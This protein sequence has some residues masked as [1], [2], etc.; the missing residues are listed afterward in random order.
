MV[1][2]YY[3]QGSERVGPVGIETL[4]EL[5]HQGVLNLESYIWKK[6]FQNW[7]RLKDVSELDF[8][9]PATASE[10]T[11]VIAPVMEE[12]KIVE[13]SPEITFNFDWNSI[14][15]EEELFFIKI[16]LIFL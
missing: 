10:R 8:S 4:R 15:S 3:V 11:P 6:G 16:Y 12:E 9:K 2:W 1:N 5:F 14:R 7:E 13:T